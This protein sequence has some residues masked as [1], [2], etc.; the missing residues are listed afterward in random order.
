MELHNDVHFMWTTIACK[1]HNDVHFM[2]TTIACK[3]HNDV[4]FMW[5]TIACKLQC[6]LQGM[7]KQ[8]NFF[9]FSKFTST[10]ISGKLIMH[11]Q[12]MLHKK[13]LSQWSI[14]PTQLMHT[15]T[16]W[17]AHTT[18]ICT[19]LAHVS[20]S[21]LFNVCVTTNSCSIQPSWYHDM[22]FVNLACLEHLKTF[23]VH[24]KHT[25]FITLPFHF[26]TQNLKHL[27]F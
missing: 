10:Y 20:R 25:R 1:L 7:N 24:E 17:E 8:W 3:L 23:L 12:D 6:K 4:H 13:P 19:S 27:G 5:T 15:Q 22:F 16:I 18:W 11:H 26:I 9:F 14:A 21:F 2:W